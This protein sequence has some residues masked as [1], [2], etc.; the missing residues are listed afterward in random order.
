[1]AKP[2]F[3]AADRLRVLLQGGASVR[4]LSEAAG[5]GI[6]LRRVRPGKDGC[7]A[8]L[9]GRDLPDL[10]RRA[11]KRQVSVR[12]LRR[13]GPG[14]LAARVWRRPGVWLGA[15]LFCVL[16]W[17]L[18]GYVW[19]IDFGALEAKQASAVRTL[20][21]QSG[22]WE[23]A[24]LRGETLQAVQDQLAAQPELFGWV[25][26]NFAG[27]CLFVESTPMESQ[28]IR[29]TTPETALYA[30][31]DAEVVAVKVESGFAQVAPGQYVAE[32]QLL[33]NAL[34]ADRDG[35]PVYQPASGSVTGR[36]RLRLSAEQAYQTEQ[37][38]LTGRSARQST[39]YLLGLEIPLEE[40]E[41]PFEQAAV[42]EEWRPLGVGQIALPGCLHVRQ[43]WEQA[44]RVQT[45]SLA[46]AEA[47][48]Q[49]A[50]VRQLLA[51]WPD[52]RIE[53]QS[54]VFEHNGNG[55]VCRAE[56]VFCADI[57]T[58]GT[59]QPLPDPTAE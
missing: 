17:L 5:A 9:L 50:C 29:T 52:A 10:L 49:R 18:S 51:D 27:G 25:S 43:L 14:R 28:Q 11:E 45:F 3:A 54:F 19:R 30:A 23:G 20:L 31:A 41:T 38:V 7:T 46:A 22:I 55:V 24:R 33:A 53:Q 4:L 35:D 34:R 56:F 57:A 40:T 37:T 44:S 42:Q 16:V 32:G 59:M 2:D 39:L 6:R 48:A 47:M 13:T 26:L 58:A 36:V 21:Q 8:D 15:V 12:I 1:M